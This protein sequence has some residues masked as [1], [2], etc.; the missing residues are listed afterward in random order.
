MNLITRVLG[1]IIDTMTGQYI[2]YGMAAILG[3]RD[4]RYAQVDDGGQLRAGTTNKVDAT[5]FHIRS[6]NKPYVTDL[7]RV[8]RYG[9]Y[10]AL[11]DSDRMFLSAKDEPQNGEVGLFVSWCYDWEFFQVAS[12]PPNLRTSNDTF[13]RYGSELALI[14]HTGKSLRYDRN[15]GYRC[16]ASVNRIGDWEIMSFFKPE[17]AHGSAQH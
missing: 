8:V 9:D 10:L 4:G 6:V 12:L 11:C 14:A 3:T 7:G 13:L 1:N 17:R 5:I 2:R 15:N 16:F